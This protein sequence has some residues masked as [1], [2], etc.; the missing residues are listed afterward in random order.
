MR[1]KSGNRIHWNPLNDWTVGSYCLT[2]HMSTSGSVRLAHPGGEEAQPRQREANTRRIKTESNSSRCYFFTACSS[3]CVNRMS[4]ISLDRYV[5]IGKHKHRR[6]ALWCTSAFSLAIS[7][8]ALTCLLMYGPLVNFLMC[9]FRIIYLSWTKKGPKWCML[10]EDQ[11]SYYTFIMFPHF[12][13]S[14]I[15]H[16][17]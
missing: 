9:M 12:L 2:S 6:E 14:N 1:Q 13:Y 5:H 10:L 16:Q 15:T 3:K 4:L 11:S 8:S 7:G 17:L